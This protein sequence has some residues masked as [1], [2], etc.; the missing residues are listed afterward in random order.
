MTEIRDYNGNGR[1]S[2]ESIQRRFESYS[3]S[4]G[5]T[6]IKLEPLTYQEGQVKWIYP[7]LDAVITGI[8]KRDPACIELGIELIEDGNSMPFGM[9]LKY[10]AARALRRS[11][12]LLTENQRTR[13]RD[14]VAEMMIA[15]YMPREFLQYL[16]LLSAIGVDSVVSR[17][18]AE[19]N[20]ENPWVRRYLERIRLSN[21]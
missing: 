11:S 13:I 2:R 21:E 9:T 16:K 4:F 12:D 5:T 10:N 15:E 18:E 3:K 19:A 17:V 7:L 8:K 1:W 20:L 6:I 14:R